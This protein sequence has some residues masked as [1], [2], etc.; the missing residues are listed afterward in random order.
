MKHE[1]K[2]IALIILF[3]ILVFSICFTYVFIHYKEKG[4]IEVIKNYYEVNISNA[5]IDYESSMS[6]KIN[7]EENYIHVD[8][9]DLKE[10][11]VIEFSYD[12]SNIGNVDLITEGYV[13]T[14]LFSNVDT[15]NIDIKASLVK[16]EVLR[17]SD[18]KK[19]IV[20]VKYSGKNDKE[21]PHCS[22]NI[23]YSFKELTL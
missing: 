4:S 15:S 12:I 9:P 18:S 6:I 13:I 8:I 7:N 19:I 5:K 16:D 10:K 20:K 3:V 22:F 14:N 21:I 2:Y 1:H 11:D 17:G 23:N